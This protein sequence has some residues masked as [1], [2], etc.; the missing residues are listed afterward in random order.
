MPLNIYYS[1]IYYICFKKDATDTNKLN[2]V[3]TQYTLLWADTGAPHYN[4]I[5]V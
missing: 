1:I 3:F 2:K 5:M 4:A